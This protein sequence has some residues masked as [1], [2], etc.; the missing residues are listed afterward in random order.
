MLDPYPPAAHSQVGVVFNPRS[1]RNGA[2]AHAAEGLPGVHVAAPARRSDLKAVLADFAARGID[3]LAISGGDGTV[4]DVLTAGMPVFG[5]RWPQMAVIPS[6]KTNALN[7]DLGAPRGWTVAGVIDA[8]G[9]GRKVVRRPLRVRDVNGGG[10]LYGFVFGAGLFTVATHAGQDAHRLG[11]FNALAV[12]AT[13]M[14]SF[15]QT[16]FG[17]DRNVFRRGAPIR[18]RTGK[19]LAE[20]PRAE[21]GDP[22]RR[23][24][25]FASSLE[26]Y[27][28]GLKPFPETRDVRAIVVDNPRRRLF[29]TGAL[30]AYGWA[31]PWL[32]RM[33]LH[34]L[35]AEVL[36]VDLTEGFVLD[37]ETF[38]GGSYELTLGPPLTFV[39]P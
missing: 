32:E 5:D 20:V 8:L 15:L 36:R 4:R 22:A 26:R 30:V 10:E 6:G 39:V 16:M 19:D 13:T 17:S 27:P 31:S 2:A 38:P 34:R 28:M 37:G 25:V 35:A 14:W 29:A 3:C 23:L 21:R 11:A 1:H 9:D 12:G 7:L 33:G 24:L 18:L